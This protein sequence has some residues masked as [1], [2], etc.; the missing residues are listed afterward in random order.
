[1]SSAARATNAAAR[2]PLKTRGSVVVRRLAS[3]LADRRVSP[4]AISVAGIAAAVLGA[5]A[6]LL[7]PHADGTAGRAGLL[8]VAAVGI[9]LRLLCN[10]LDGLVAVEGGLGTPDGELFNDVPDR[11][12]DSL[13]LVAAGY[14]GGAP[15]LGWTAALIAALTAY[16]RMIGGASGLPQD[17]SG[18]MSK[19]R[20][21]AALTAACAVAV[22]DHRALAVGVGLIAAGSALTCAGRLLRLRRALLAAR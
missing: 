13:L 14:A 10:L 1:M 11:I 17:F 8:A 7:V 6:L 22:A 5:A 4:N 18:V 20:R 16:I 9:Q 15:A 21:M 2:R 12:T 3:G 19:P